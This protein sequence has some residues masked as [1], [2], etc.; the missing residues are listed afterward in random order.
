MRMPLPSK[1]QQ[2]SSTS[3]LTCRPRR[4]L[5]TVSH[6]SKANGSISI[7]QTVQLVRSFWLSADNKHFYVRL[8]TKDLTGLVM[9]E[10]RPLSTGCIYGSCMSLCLCFLLW[11]GLL[12]TR[13]LTDLVMPEY[14]PGSILHIYAWLLFVTVFVFYFVYIYSGITQMVECSTKSFIHTEF[15]C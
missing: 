9:P 13:G 10:C 7:L 15:R 5:L 11:N 1:E 3:C 2:R 12:Y 6:C 4:N 8:D 14:R